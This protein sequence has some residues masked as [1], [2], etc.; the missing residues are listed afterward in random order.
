VRIEIGRLFLL[1]PAAYRLHEFEVQRPI[2]VAEDGF[3]FARNPARIAAEA[4]LD[5]F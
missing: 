2:T 4:R 1:D 5:G 3:T